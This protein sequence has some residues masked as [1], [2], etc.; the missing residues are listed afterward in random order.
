MNLYKKMCC[1]TLDY[2]CL[3]SC[4]GYGKRVTRFPQNITFTILPTAFTLSPSGIDP[5][6]LESGLFDHLLQ[7]PGNRRVVE[8]IRSGIWGRVLREEAEARLDL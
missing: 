8:E 5:R 6:V 2:R 4:S 1:S 3:K 7:T